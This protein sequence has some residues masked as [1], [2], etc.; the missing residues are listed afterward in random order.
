MVDSSPCIQTMDRTKSLH[1][2]ITGMLQEG[3]R[4]CPAVTEHPPPPLHPCGIIVCLYMCA[5]IPL[6]ERSSLRRKHA[7]CCVAV[8]H[9]G[10]WDNGNTA[11]IVCM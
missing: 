10:C 9:Y 11:M 4:M 6:S 8:F 2:Q 1:N 5:V 3:S 7:G